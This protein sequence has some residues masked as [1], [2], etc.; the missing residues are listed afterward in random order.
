MFPETKYLHI[1]KKLQIL[2]A[3]PYL[4]QGSVGFILFCFYF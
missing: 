1:I 2:L 3:I 4:F